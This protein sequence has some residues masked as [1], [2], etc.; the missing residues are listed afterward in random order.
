[1]P[2]PGRGDRRRGPPPRARGRRAGRVGLRVRL[3]TTPAS[4]GTTRRGAGSASTCRDHPGERGDDSVREQAAEDRQG[5]P[6]RARGRRL[7]RPDRPFPDGTTPASAGTTDRS[8]RTGIHRWDHPRE[9]GD[10]S[11]EPGRAGCSRG[12]PPR[13]RGRPAEIGQPGRRLGTTP[14]SAGTTPTSSSARCPGCGPPPRARGRLVRGLDVAL[15]PGTTPA[16][17]GTTR[18]T[19]VPPPGPW[20]HPR[21]RGDD[22]E[23]ELPPLNPSGPPPRARGRRDHPGHAG[24]D[25][26][27]TPASAGTTRSGPSRPHGSGDHPRERG[28]DTCWRSFIGT[29]QG[30]P[31]RARGRPQ[32]RR[33]P[34]R[35]AGTTPASAGTTSP[36]AAGR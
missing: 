2:V 11:A 20:D 22:Q 27:T 33:S 16:S 25:R 9:R 35:P 12:P 5:P 3:G 29:Y 17:A 13:A 30:P 24:D 31:P 36:A 32:P 34:R 15:G 10:D 18:R 7:A 1:M 28:D 4:V 8:V 23:I 14:A 21:E 26:G 6:P 19:P